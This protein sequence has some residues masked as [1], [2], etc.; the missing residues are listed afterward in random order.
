MKRIEIPR[1]PWALSVVGLLVS[2]LSSCSSGPER[3]PAEAPE[4]G[5]APESAEP[6][7]ESR[8]P[9]PLERSG[10][11]DVALEAEKKLRELYLARLE[12][13]LA[14]QKARSAEAEGAAAVLLARY[15]EKAAQDALGH[16]RKVE[17][18]ELLEREQ[19]AIDKQQFELERA[20]R[21]LAQLEAELGPQLSD[22]QGKETAELVLWRSRTK[23]ELAGR[24]LNLLQAGKLRIESYEIPRRTG[25]LAA[26]AKEKSD[27]LLRA[28]EADEQAGYQAKIDTTRAENKVDLLTLE[29]A[30]LRARG[31]DN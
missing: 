6:A 24:E 5:G 7:P 31:I 29:L 15:A 21:E 13:E 20:Q 17:A 25:E 28:E 4:P 23:V 8:V 14:R 27:A 22:E 2:L 10:P 9:E 16:Y 30:E 26:H 19:L 12:L 1:I 11:D 18:P 3:V